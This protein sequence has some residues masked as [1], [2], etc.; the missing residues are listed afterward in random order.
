MGLPD[1]K[2]SGRWLVLAATWVGCGAIERDP[3]A[4]P[5]PTE[6]NEAGAPPN[7][8]TQNSGSRLVATC[9]PE[10]LEKGCGNR[11]CPST[12]D[13][14]E[15]RC[16]T[17]GRTSRSATACG[18]TAVTVGFG[19]GA[20]I[21]YFNGNGKLVGLVLEGDVIADCPDSTLSSAHS[22]GE[23]CEAVGEPEDACAAGCGGD[24]IECGD[25]RICPP[26]YRDLPHDVCQSG[27]GMTSTTTSC[28][29][30]IVTMVTRE[31]AGRYF[32]FDPQENLIGQ[33]TQNE[34]GTRTLERGV[35]CEARG[36][37]LNLCG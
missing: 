29:G 25:E 37:T 15:L 9:P 30:T 18:G 1:R 3:A 36:T 33:G 27:G 5:A 2:W 16:G 35:D 31:G 13:D 28:G 34:D 10:P 14:V 26:T 12:V 20:D 23:T 21:W 8:G 4:Q 24:P 32:C 19:F 6:T 7:D 11:R 17:N 22:Y